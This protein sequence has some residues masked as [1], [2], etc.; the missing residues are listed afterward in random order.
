VKIFSNA[1]KCFY[2][3]YRNSKPLGIGINN[4]S[5]Y[6]ID[7]TPDYHYDNKEKRGGYNQIV[8]MLSGMS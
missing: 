4:N 2:R 8:V 1:G 7:F 5:G 3:R 6:E